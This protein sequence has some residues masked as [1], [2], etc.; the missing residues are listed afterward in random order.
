MPEENKPR[1]CALYVRVSTTNQAE[2]GE[3]L[4]EQEERLINFCK[5]KGWN[6]YRIYREE[7]YSGKDTKRPAFLQMMSDIYRGDINTV[8]VKKIDRLSRSIIDFENIYKVFE[9]KEVDL[10]SLQEN[11]DTSTALGRG[12]IRIVLVF[13]QLEREQTAERTIDI[14]TYRAKQGLFNGGYPRLGYDIDYEN[15]K[16]VPNESE[17]PIVK[18]AFTIYLKCGSLS[19]TAKILNSKGYRMK[20]WTSK[21]G[22]RFIGKK[23]TKNNLSRLLNDPIYIGK[24][25]Y[26]GNIYD[27]QHPAIIDEETFDMVQSILRANSVTKTGYRQDDNKFLLK[28]LVFCG[29]CHSAM[30]PSFSISKGK[31][32]FYYRCTTNNDR[33]KKKCRIGYVSAPQLEKL[34]V[35][36]LKFLSKDPRIIEGIVENAT[37][38]QKEELAELLQKKKMLSDN[39]SQIDRKAR[40]L[41]DILSESD[42]I[43]EQSGYIVDRLKELEDQSAQIR[44]ELES[45]EFEINER[46]N[47]IISAD[48]IRK[49]L[50]DFSNIYNNLTQDEKYDFLHLLIKKIRYYENKDQVPKNKK[51]GTI[52]MDLWELPPIDPKYLNSAKSFAESPDWLPGQDSNLRPSG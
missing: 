51:S 13:A 6:D 9:A 25:R 42:T 23:F 38:T 46:R 27:G 18:D 39:L 28:G 43:N 36:E 24:I 5:F 50:K 20:S 41:V 21:S 10:I 31:K 30:A 16:L 48:V 32:Y 47:K 7:G 17:I 44:K 4:D 35:E 49:S 45:L 2:D 40:N 8:I 52:K 37:K 33:S 11:F 34:V 1:K 19:E 22:R 26:K 14:M 3:S 12:V 29:S 15:K